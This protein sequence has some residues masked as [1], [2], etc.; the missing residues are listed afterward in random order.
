MLRP[1]SSIVLKRAI[2]RNATVIHRAP[3]LARYHSVGTIGQRRRAWAAP[4]GA[5]RFLRPSSPLRQLQSRAFRATTSV[6]DQKR[7]YYEVLGVSRSA[8]AGEVKKAYYKLA[9]EMHPDLNKDDPGASDKFSELQDAYETVSDPE[10]RKMYDQFGHAGANMGGGGFGGGG[11]NPFGGGFHGGQGVDPEDILRGF[12]D[13]FGGGFGQGQN[14]NAPQR[15]GDLQARL[16]LNFMEA[17][18]GCSKDLNIRRMMTCKPCNGT[19][20]SAGSG[21][22]TCKACSG[23]GSRT[24]QR[25]FLYMQSPCPNCKGTGSVIE[26]PCQPCSGQGRLPETKTVEVKV[27]SGVDTGINLRVVG[28]GDDGLRGGGAGHLFVEIVVKEDPFFKRDQSDVHVEVPISFVQACLGDKIA[29]PTLKGE[30]DLKVPSGTQPGDR[31]VMRNRGVPVLNGGGRRGHQYVHFDVKVPKKL[32]DRQKELLM[33]FA[34]EAG[35]EAVVFDEADANESAGFFSDAAERV[36]KMFG[37]N[38]Q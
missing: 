25:G 1:A 4:P 27:P 21:P 13:M 34:E 9:K 29:M 7:D 23:T 5:P 17:V 32:T 12:S 24:V 30:V 33:E 11:G 3:P 6:A 14:R 15:G 10:K 18:A 35:D 31:L 2:N 26:S 8:S 28:Q 22:V 16:V 38:E 37:S 20:A 19:G 36:K